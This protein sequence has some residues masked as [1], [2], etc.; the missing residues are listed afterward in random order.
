MTNTNSGW[1]FP[2]TGAPDV[3]VK[4]PLLMPTTKPGHVLLKV[5]ASG[6]N[7]IDTK[8]RAGLAP[9]ASDNH[10]PGCDVCG[11][12][13]SLGEGVTEF[14]LGDLVYGCA[15][16]VKGSSGT[17]CEYMCADAELLA[18]KPEAITPTQASILPLISITAFEALERLSVG[19]GDELLI[20]GGTGGVG[21]MAIQ[22]AKLNGARVTATAGSKEGLLFIESLGANAVLHS[23]ASAAGSPFNKVLD[24]HGGESFQNALLAAAPGAQVATI[25]ARNIYDLAQA[26]AK[27]LTIHAVFMLLPL[28]TGNGRKAHGDFLAWLA[29][30]IES[31]SIQTPVMQEKMASEVAEVHRSYEAGKLKIKTAFVI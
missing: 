18:C 8:I 22:L 13:I 25:N 30:E 21:Q 20:M 16:G 3:L 31:G 17:L 4:E 26:H 6:F 29:N 27:A 19:A 23:E 14:A 9:I 2:M 5:K 24:S 12:V 10:V 15:G 7:P 1:V 11:E 28:I